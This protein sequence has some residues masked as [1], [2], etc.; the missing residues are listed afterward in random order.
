MLW[1]AACCSLVLT[2]SPSTTPPW[3]NLSLLFVSGRCGLGLGEYKD[4]AAEDQPLRCLGQAVSVGLGQ[5]LLVQMAACELAGRTT[6]LT[7]PRT[8]RVTAS[9]CI[10]LRIET[11]YGSRAAA[12]D[13]TCPKQC[14][15]E[16]EGQVSLIWHQAACML[17][18]C[19]S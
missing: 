10:V 12:H 8:P 19:L 15:G 18:V 4:G 9:Q 7:H 16:G 5:G 17:M 2:Y 3:P 1:G 13:I 6:P 11:V 14:A